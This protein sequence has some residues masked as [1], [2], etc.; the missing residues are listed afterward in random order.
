MEH[1]VAALGIF[2]TDPRL[3]SKRQLLSGRGVISYTTSVVHATHWSKSNFVQ[4]LTVDVLSVGPRNLFS[5]YP[6]LSG[7]LFR[8]YFFSAIIQK[9]GVARMVWDW[10]RCRK[11]MG[12]SRWCVELLARLIPGANSFCSKLQAR[13]PNPLNRWSTKSENG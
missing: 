1:S 13:R 3:S 5:S 7:L 9:A 8:R 2:Y 10:F 11:S 6:I 12:R 4:S